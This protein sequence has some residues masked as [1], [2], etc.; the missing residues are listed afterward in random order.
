M[1]EEEIKALSMRNKALI[2]ESKN[3]A[4]IHQQIARASFMSYEY[5]NDAYTEI[6]SDLEAFK[7]LITDVYC[8]INAEML[9]DAHRIYGEKLISTMLT[10]PEEF[11][12]L[13]ENN[14]DLALIKKYYPNFNDQLITQL[15]SDIENFRQLIPTIPALIEIAKEHPNHAEAL[16]GLVLPNPEEFNRL[17]RNNNDLIATARHFPNHAEALITRVLSN[18]EE[19]NRFIQNND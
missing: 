11:K 12:R 8:L 10:H 9:D 16:I 5:T 18:P 19:F 1:T 14:R 7:R 3:L 4:E 15:T 17:I 2:R 6:A 13:V